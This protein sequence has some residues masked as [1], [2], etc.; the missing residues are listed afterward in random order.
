MA[1]SEPLTLTVPPD[2]AQW[3]RDAVSAGEYASVDDALADAVSTWSRREEEREDELAWIR[4]KV[5]ASLADPDPD[6]SEE[7]VDERLRLIAV[8]LDHAADEAA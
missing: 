7:E 4:A 2:V 5:R 6:L 8:N 3:L 1:S